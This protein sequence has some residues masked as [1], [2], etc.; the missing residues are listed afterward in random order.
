MTERIRKICALL[1][2]ARV[3]ADIGC[4]HGYMTE[5]MLVSGRC[6]RAYISDIS[7][8]SLQKAETLL[9]PYIAAGK[10]I[11]VVADGLSGIPEPC[12]L[13]LIA[14]MGGEEIV[15]ILS[16]GP[17][18]E[19]F[20]LQPMK[21]TPKVREYLLSQG[22]KIECDLTFSEG[23]EK[24]K[25]Y[26]ILK[27]TSCGEDEYS[28]M[29]RKYGRDNLRGA[30]E[31]FLQKMQEE[32]EKLAFRMQRKMQPQSRRRLLEEYEEIGEIIDE[33]KRNL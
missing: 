32:R 22:A 25:Y 2:A 13:V 3:F 18:P 9:A 12:D 17:L 7:P 27:G 14:G 11:P 16:L 30:S 20:V 1:P 33:I 5:Y 23:A 21:N 4:D 10:C 6:E 26:D 19:K 15:K 31:A 8:K 24:K 29:E 28:P